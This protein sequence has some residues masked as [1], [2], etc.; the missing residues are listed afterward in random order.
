MTRR[1][2]ML[3]LW[4]SVLPLSAAEV[5]PKR[6]VD[7][8]ESPTAVCLGPDGR[9][10]VT[11]M[12][13]AGKEGDGAIVAIADGKA[14]PFA[15]GLDDPTGIVA[16]NNQF[17]VPDRTAA[18]R[19]IDKSGKAIVHSDAKAFPSLPQFLN[20]ITVDQNGV[21]YVSDSGDNSAGAVFR[22]PPK[23]KPDRVRTDILKAPHG[24]TMDGA[25]N[26]LLLMTRGPFTDYGWQTALR[27]GWAISPLSIRWL[28]TGAGGSIWAAS[29]AQSLSCS[30]HT[31][32]R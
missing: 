21:L 15:S 29:M 6:I 2:A 14:T 24:L 19:R 11:V 16:F 3:W 26:C 10:Y 8:L 9:I 23:G 7:G 30:S 22:V 25:R 28:G 18:V 1:L 17:F 31:K 5:K 20:D 32:N 27:S 12:G 4:A 13:E